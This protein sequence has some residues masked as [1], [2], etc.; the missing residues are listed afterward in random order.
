MAIFQE[1]MNLTKLKGLEILELEGPQRPATQ[2][3]I[4][5]ENLLNLYRICCLPSLFENECAQ[6]NKNVLA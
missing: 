6:E 4:F 2:S 3:D 1:T 5:W